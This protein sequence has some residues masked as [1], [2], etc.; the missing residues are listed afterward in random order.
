MAIAKSLNAVEITLDDHILIA[1]HK[2]IS[3]AESGVNMGDKGSAFRVNETDNLRVKPTVKKPSAR[4]Q[5]IADK[6]KILQERSSLAKL[7]NAVKKSAG[8]DI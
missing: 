1:G 3:L 2:A 7:S 8:L 5:L 4:E 6:Q